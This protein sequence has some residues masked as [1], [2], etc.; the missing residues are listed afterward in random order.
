V[1]GNPLPQGP[2]STCHPTQSGAKA[3]TVDRVHPATCCLSPRNKRKT[4]LILILGDRV[5]SS[6]RIRFPAQSIPIICGRS[7]HVKAMCTLSCIFS[8]RTPPARHPEAPVTLHCAIS[9]PHIDPGRPDFSIA[10]QACP[11]AQIHI[12]CTVCGS[13]PNSAPIRIS[14]EKRIGY[15]DKMACGHVSGG[16]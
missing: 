15:T 14:P 1:W 11:S 13:N 2:R 9:T 12:E 3:G 8:R 16:L 4:S 10:T 6:R 5:R 7:A